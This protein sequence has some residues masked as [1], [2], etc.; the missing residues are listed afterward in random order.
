L[1]ACAGEPAN[2]LTLFY[3][4]P[5]NARPVDGEFFSVRVFD[6]SGA[7]IAE[8]SGHLS[9]SGAYPNGQSCGAVCQRGM[10]SEG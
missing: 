3:G 1:R 9:Y 8:R 5:L 2:E 10:L 7:L 4:L 6:A